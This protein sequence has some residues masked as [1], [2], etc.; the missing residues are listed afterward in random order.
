MKNF[1][2][3]ENDTVPTWALGNQIFLPEKGFYG[4]NN[5]L[6]LWDF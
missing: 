5:A 3:G 2:D 6:E 4:A 1:E